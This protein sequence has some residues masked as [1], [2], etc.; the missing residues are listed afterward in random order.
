MRTFFHSQSNGRFKNDIP[1]GIGM[2][3]I[4]ADVKNRI[5]KRHFEK[6]PF[7]RNNPGMV[8]FAYIYHTT[9]DRKAQWIAEHVISEIDKLFPI[10][11][12]KNCSH[13]RMKLLSFATVICENKLPA[14]G[15]YYLTQY[16]EYMFPNAHYDYQAYFEEFMSWD[17][18]RNYMQ[19]VKGVIARYF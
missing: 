10:D 18:P 19:E 8:D 12:I 4:E 3:L 16:D 5:Q 13:C 17:E 2:P 14:Q 6:H 7:A 15:N 11:S 1:I 9:R